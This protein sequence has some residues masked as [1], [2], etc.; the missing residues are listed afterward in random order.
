MNENGWV[1]VGN[2]HLEVVRLP[3]VPVPFDDNVIRELVLQDSFQSLEEL[4]IPSSAAVLNGNVHRKRVA[5][6]IEGHWDAGRI[7]VR[8][9]SSRGFAFGT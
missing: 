6:N 3:L 7:R 5:R 8:I 1:R 2:G 4:I 9:P